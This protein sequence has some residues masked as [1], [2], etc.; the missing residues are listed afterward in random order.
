MP[1]H[2]FCDSVGLLAE[3]S[4][5]IFWLLYTAYPEAIHAPLDEA[6]DGS[7]VHLAVQNWLLPGDITDFLMKEL[8]VAAATAAGRG[9]DGL[10]FVPNQFAF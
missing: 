4:R 7:I 2:I 9:K 3:K 10:P 8:P 5:E 6:E 1:I